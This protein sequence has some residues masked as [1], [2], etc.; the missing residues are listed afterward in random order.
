MVFIAIKS[1]G[2]KTGERKMR[3]KLELTHTEIVLDTELSSDTEIVLDHRT[4]L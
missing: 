2:F 1:N 4:F 3:Y